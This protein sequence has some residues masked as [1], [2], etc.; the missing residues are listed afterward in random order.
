[1]DE[2]DGR[3]VSRRR[4][5][6]PDI[7]GGGGGNEASGAN[8]AIGTMTAATATTTVHTIVHNNS[9]IGLGMGTNQ[10]GIDGIN[11][12]DKKNMLNDNNRTETRS[13]KRERSGSPQVVEL[14]ENEPIPFK[15]VLTGLEGAAFQSRY[16]FAYYLFQI[17]FLRY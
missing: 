16:F 13:R 7:D 4:K 5:N 12:L 3:R 8:D 6:K 10:Y 17:Y 2:T 1:M 14:K 11:Q 9:N 15:D